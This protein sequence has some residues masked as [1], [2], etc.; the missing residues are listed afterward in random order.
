LKVLY[1]LKP[2]TSKDVAE[3]RPK[4]LKNQAI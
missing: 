1:Q 4:L 3:S 2:L